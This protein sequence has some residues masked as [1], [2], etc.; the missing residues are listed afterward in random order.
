MRQ[1]ARERLQCLFRAVFLPEGEQPVDQDHTEY[2][3]AQYRHT[4]TGILEFG[5]EGERGGDPEY[6][7]EK[8][9]EAFKKACNP[10]FPA[11]ALD[12]IGSELGQPSRDLVIRQPCGTGVQTPEGFIGREAMNLHALIL[13]LA[14]WRQWPCP[15]HARGKPSLATVGR[16]RPCGS[17]FQESPGAW[18]YPAPDGLPR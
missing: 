17:R 3:H 2:R 6:Q 9:G 11:H 5:E 18:D 4:V 1:Q 7:R 13:R 12:T 10:S 14:V 8:M 15:P 16:R